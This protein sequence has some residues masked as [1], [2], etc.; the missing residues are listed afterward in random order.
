MRFLSLSLFQVSGGHLPLPPPQPPRGLASPM[1]GPLQFKKST[2]DAGIPHL[3]M[4]SLRNCSITT[5]TRWS[6]WRSGR[7]PM[8]SAP[9]SCST[10]ISSGK[11]KGAITP[12]GPNGNLRRCD[13]ERWPCR[14]GIRVPRGPAATNEEGR[15]NG[16]RSPLGF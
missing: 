16:D 1:T 13:W 11:L 2:S 8:Y 7:L 3:L 4:A 12:T 5:E 10:G 14:R 6:T 9:I 15:H